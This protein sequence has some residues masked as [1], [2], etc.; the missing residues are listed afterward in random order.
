MDERTCGTYRLIAELGR[1]GMADVFL[2]VAER[3]SRMG[4]A[5]L[6]VVKRLRP[7]LA[8]DEELVGMFLDDTVGDTAKRR[9][10]GR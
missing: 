6:A 7:N 3:P 2:A 10:T 5:K 8:E 9:G 1:G 4:F